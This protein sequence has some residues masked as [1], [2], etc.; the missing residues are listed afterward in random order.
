[1]VRN[2]KATTRVA[3]GIVGSVS[4]VA[5]YAT[6]F[7]PQP[8]DVPIR[9]LVLVCLLA[10][11]VGAATWLVGRALPDLLVPY[12][13]RA[14]RVWVL[15]SLVA[16]IVLMLAIPIRLQPPPPLNRLEVVALR[17]KNPESVSSEVWVRGLTIQGRSVP[18]SDF[19]L[20]GAWDT[21][22][23]YLSS[24]AQDRA[25]LRWE[26]M[27]HEAPTLA[28][29]AHPWSGK[30]EI[31][32]NDERRVVDLYSPET[33]GEWIELPV[34]EATRPDLLLIISYGSISVSIAVMLLLAGLLLARIPAARRYE[35]VSSWSWLWYAL[36]CMVVWSFF[37]LATWPGVL[38]NDSID[39]WRQMIGRIPVNDHHPAAHTFISWLVTR[40][41]LSPAAVVV[42]QI[43]T[44]ALVFGVLMRE[45]ALW[46]VPRWVLITIT[47]LFSLS[48]TN[49]MMVVTLWKDT[50]YST[51][52]LGLFTVLVRSV[53]TH[54]A[55]LRTRGGV[56]CLALA[57]LF[58]SLLRHN[59]LWLCV[60]LVL[61]M[62]FVFGRQVRRPVLVAGALAYAMVLIV[63]GPLYDLAQVN[64][65]KP[66]PATI[67]IH[68][69]SAMLHAGAQLDAE[70]LAVLSTYQPLSYWYDKY[71]CYAATQLVANDIAHPYALSAGEWEYLRIWAQYAPRHLD[72]L[73]RHQLCVTSMIWRITQPHE[74]DAHMSVPIAYII[75]N[76]LG[77]T[78][79]PILPGLRPLLNQLWRASQ[80]N[81]YNW[82][83][84]RPALYM[85]VGL[86][87][88]AIAAV[89]TRTW[90]MLLLGAPIAISSGILL[91]TS[92]N[93]AFRYQ[94]PVYLIGLVSIALLFVVH[95]VLD[96]DK[97]DSRSLQGS[98]A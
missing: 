47:A 53:R 82:L 25:I 16:G 27:T 2:V 74:S 19:K 6:F 72:T 68:Q 83:T 33:R 14:R 90:R 15:S 81:E 78:T 59:G 49:G 18:F 75:E 9:V 73:V 48:I 98:E 88:V 45:F 76:D 37:L 97:A 46:Q 20:E 17:E 60:P 61:I 10:A 40:I 93:Q 8:I 44:L 62:L 50:L 13:P 39:Q 23:G 79:Q 24:T 30:V 91:V 36:P 89:R 4:A 34:T 32:W 35:K 22:D 64:R 21:V 26:G 52:V 58:T 7:R 80:D 84:W 63:R 94:Y 69:I 77:L 96:Q 38:T 67:V 28:F 92:I 31:I 3:V 1:M 86:A 54:G 12:T 43:V 85:Y 87:C 5:A 57:L 56:A 70:Q 71:S 66:S 65:I 11:G 29:L 41:W 95:P 51:A 55:W 42:T